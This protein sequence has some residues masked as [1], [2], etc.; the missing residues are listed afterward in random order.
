MTASNG[1]KRS[2]ER[3]SQGFPTLFLWPTPHSGKTRSPI[4]YEKPGETSRNRE[5]PGADTRGNKPKP[6]KT[7][8]NKPTYRRYTTLVDI[9]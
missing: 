8:K 9:V 3:H 5:K 2:S 4:A 7:Q 6:I 1:A